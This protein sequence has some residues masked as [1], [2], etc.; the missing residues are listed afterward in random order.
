M[1]SFLSESS[2]LSE[3]FCD[4]VNIREGIYTFLW[5]GSSQQAKEL[6]NIPE[7]LLRFQWLEKTDNSYYEFRIERDE[8]T[9]DISLIITDFAETDEERASSRL[10]WNSQIDKLCKVMG[11]YS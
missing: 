8:L 1:Y 9:S 11:A 7:K 6:K 3:W 2:G 5:E 4:D 10:L